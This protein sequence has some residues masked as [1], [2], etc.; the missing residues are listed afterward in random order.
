MTIKVP[1]GI[2]DGMTMRMSGMGADGESGYPPGDLYVEVQVAKDS[3]FS[4]EGQD[5]YVNLPI[6]ITQVGG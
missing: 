5:I 2:D 4:R 6:S 1:G 3:Y